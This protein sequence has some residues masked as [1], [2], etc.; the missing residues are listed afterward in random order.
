MKNSRNIITHNLEKLDFM[1]PPGG[2]Q[3]WR[4]KAGMREM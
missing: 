3:G 4:A 1:Q 2:G